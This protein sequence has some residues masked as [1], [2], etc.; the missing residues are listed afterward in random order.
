[1]SINKARLQS[2]IK[3]SVFTPGDD[4]Y[5]K[6]LKRWAGN[7]ERRAGYVVFVES[8]EDIS[9]TVQ[10]ILLQLIQVGWATKNELELVV[11]CGG[12][13]GTGASSTEGGVVGTTTHLGQI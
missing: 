7:W 10:P 1:M 12:H 2:E 13:S 9:K 5:E 4:G 11:K 3:G 6:S 8:A